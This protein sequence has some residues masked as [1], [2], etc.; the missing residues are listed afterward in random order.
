MLSF[1]PGVNI[2]RTV[3]Q[4]SPH[5]GG[6]IPESKR[7]IATVFLISTKCSAGVIAAR[8]SAPREE[9]FIVK[10]GEFRENASLHG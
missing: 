5:L 6:A 10:N 1:Y 8:I 7:R 4:A 2:W 9:L 3:G